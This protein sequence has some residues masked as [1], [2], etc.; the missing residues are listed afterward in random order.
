MIEI[1]AVVATMAGAILII[2][3]LIL[4]MI[5]SL[6]KKKQDQESL[7][8]THSAQIRNASHWVSAK[9]QGS[10]EIFE[11]LQEVANCIQNGYWVDGNR[12]RTLIEQIRAKNNTYE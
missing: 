7:L 4:I 2:N 8:I 6:R 9:D 1:Y 10:E 12:L 11:V 3:G 5:F